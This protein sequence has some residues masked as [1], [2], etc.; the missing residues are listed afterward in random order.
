VAYSA[1]GDGGLPSAQAADTTLM[2]A[3]GGRWVIESRGVT[4]ETIVNVGV[5]VD[6]DKKTV[7]GLA[8]S[9]FRITN[10]T[11]TTITFLVVEEYWSMSGA[12]DRLT[13]SL[14]AKGGRYTSK[15]QIAEWMHSYDLQCRPTQRMF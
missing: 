8:D 9:L 7:T 13:G 2:L 6:L 11:E 1:G 5:I 14:V 3:C 12:L 15:S 4:S 10:I